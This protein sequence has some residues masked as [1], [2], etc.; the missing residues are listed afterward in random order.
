MGPIILV[1]DFATNCVASSGVAVLAGVWQY[2]NVANF[3][4]LGSGRWV[5]TRQP[6]EIVLVVY[7]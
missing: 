2:F 7:E 4:L 5:V 1:C 6:F 3:N